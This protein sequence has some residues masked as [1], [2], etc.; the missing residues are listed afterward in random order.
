MFTRSR[1][2]GKSSAIAPAIRLHHRTERENG[3]DGQEEGQRHK[4]NK[5]GA[6]LGNHDIPRVGSGTSAR[7]L[8]KDYTS[9]ITVLLL[10]R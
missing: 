2:T 3:D 9:R 10:N 7:S 8:W 5:S 6:K 4:E 1:L